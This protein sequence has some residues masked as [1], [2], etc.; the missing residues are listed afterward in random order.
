M[1]EDDDD[2]GR[3]G[4]AVEGVDPIKRLASPGREPVFIDWFF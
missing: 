4:G 3:F 1:R 2:P